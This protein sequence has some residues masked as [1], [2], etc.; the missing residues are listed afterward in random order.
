MDKKLKMI[1]S[2][3]LNISTNKIN[4]KFE[5]KFEKKWDSINNIKILLEI[6]KF[7]KIRFEENDFHKKMNII[8]LSQRIKIK[9][10]KK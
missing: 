5:P 7:F 6:E 2:K 9:L 3:V 10:K 4:K 8:E 1:I